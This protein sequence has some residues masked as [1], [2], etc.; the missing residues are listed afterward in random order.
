MALVVTYLTEY[1]FA[2]LVERVQVLGLRA[3]GFE[4]KLFCHCELSSS[5]AVLMKCV[6]D[7]AVFWREGHR[8]APLGPGRAMFQEVQLRMEDGSD[9]PSWLRQ[10]FVT[11]V[12]KLPNLDPVARQLVMDLYTLSPLEQMAEIVAVINNEEGE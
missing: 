5:G 1:R 6:G 9:A 3:E 11:A 2:L 7:V 8:P 4:A 12:G 10:Q